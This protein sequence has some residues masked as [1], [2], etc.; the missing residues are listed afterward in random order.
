MS[1]SCGVSLREAAAL[2]GENKEMLAFLHF[3]PVFKGY[4]CDEIV[5]ELYKKGVE[6]CF[7]GHIHGNYE[8]AAVINY[9]DIDFYLIS[10]DF[11]MFEP[12]KIEPKSKKSFDHIL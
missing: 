2:R 7:F 12:M 1:L 10:A 6:R 4:L 9:S 3:Q 5:L 11:L 8:A